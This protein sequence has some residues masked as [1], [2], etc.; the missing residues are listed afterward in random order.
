M[1]SAVKSNLR[2]S[3]QSHMALI[4]K[5]INYLKANPFH[6]I[7]IGAAALLILIVLIVIVSLSAKRRKA[8]KRLAAEKALAD[9]AAQEKLAAE[10]AAKEKE[11]EEARKLAAKKAVE[12]KLEAQRIIA[13][14]EEADRKAKEEA[15]RVAA[16]AAEKARLAAEAEAK[17][18][19]AASA[20]AKAKAKVLAAEKA[21]KKAQEKAEKERL[22]AEEA[23]KQA[24]IAETVKKQTPLPQKRTANLYDELV[25]HVNETEE[26]KAARYSGK[27]T[28]FRLLTDEADSEE[29]YF[30]ELHASNGEKLL[31]S[32]EYTSYAGA[33][34]GIQ[35][36]KTNIE[37]DNFKI[38]LSKKGDYIFKL[39]SG[40][41]MLLCM[42]EHYAT[43][44]RCESAIEST[45]RFAKTAVIDENV[46]DCKVKVPVEDETETEPLPEGY[47]GKWIIE[48]HEAADGERVFYFELFANNGE[49]LLSSEEYTTYIGAVN[50]IQTHKTNIERGNFRVSLTKRG[51]Y[52]YKL[53]NGNGQLLCLGEH[54]ATKRRCINAVESVKRFAASSPILTDPEHTK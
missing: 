48:C 43:K 54:Y 15:D 17:A 39:L 31:S 29:T 11:Q 2:R 1:I 40:K 6:A 30:F 41:N 23:K 36:H 13:E 27:W 20:E 25:E 24:E 26:E 8:K 33:V 18:K 19:A 3:I 50:G 37:K 22:A 12:D 51:D 4:E 21:A 34:R 16:E 35:T 14:R 46:Q 42:G 32:E 9:K 49:K 45:K 38:T 52:I 47:N 53:L 7:V 44:A 5:C 10:R 28:I